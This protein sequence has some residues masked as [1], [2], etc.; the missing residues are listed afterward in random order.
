MRKRRRPRTIALVQEIASAKP[1]PTGTRVLQFSKDPVEGT[2]D[3]IQHFRKRAEEDPNSGIFEYLAKALFSLGVLLSER[4]RY[5]EAVLAGEEVVAIRR[6]LAETDPAFK[7]DLGYAFDN[8]ACD[9]NRAGRRENAAQAYEEAIKIRR[10]L[11]KTAHPRAL[12][13]MKMALGSSLQ[14]L[15]ANLSQM[16]HIKDGAEMYKEAVSLYKVMAESDPSS[17][18]NHVLARSLRGLGQCFH[19]LFHHND[20]ARVFNKDL[21][22]LDHSLGFELQQSIRHK[23]AVRAINKD[24]ANSLQNLSIS[25]H[26]MGEYEYA[27][28]SDE[29]AVTLYRSFAEM[30]PSIKESLAGS[31]HR[32]G[33]GLTQV[34]RYEE[35][36]CVHAEVASYYRM[37]AE[38]DLTLNKELARSLHYLAFDLHVVGHYEDAW[39][40]IWL[41][42]YSTSLEVTPRWAIMK[43]QYVSS[44]KAWLIHFVNL[45]TISVLLADTKTRHAPKL[46]RMR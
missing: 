20:A 13:S 23:D 11:V 17:D 19:H 41:R 29:E 33:V 26:H 39:S 25:L 16:G 6:N 5:E 31:L 1:L 36:L 10:E 38:M 28:R 9:L 42:Q 46:K 21:G 18:V 3:T 8:L 15:G 40:K 30:D 4:G 32:L 7:N 27:V 22:Q 12:M 37:M 44:M 14:N 35:A 2:K 45:V 34:G 24:L 43:P